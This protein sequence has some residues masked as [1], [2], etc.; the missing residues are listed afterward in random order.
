MK[1]FAPQNTITADSTST[2]IK[3]SLNSELKVK[4]STTIT[5]IPETPVRFQVQK[6][7]T[8]RKKIKHY[9]PSAEDSIKYNLKVR[10]VNNKSP[11]FDN[12][13]NDY[14]NPIPRSDKQWINTATTDNSGVIEIIKHE[15]ENEEI[16][17]TLNSL[18]LE[19]DSI[20]NQEN[21]TRTETQT[22]VGENSKLKEGQFIS[23]T[24]KDVISG[25]LIFVIAIVGFLRISN[26]KYLKELFSSLIYSQAA[27]KLTTTFSTQ[28]Q[29]PSFVLNVLFVLN[30]S[31][32][33]YL[34]SSYF[35][36]SHVKLL[37]L[38]LIPICML[39]IL[40]YFTFKAG[41]YRLVAYIFDTTDQTKEYLWIGQRHSKIGSLILLPFIA[42]IPYIE[43]S[44]VEILLKIGILLM[45]S[46][47][48][49]QIT[50]GLQLI[51]G[52]IASLFYL[53]LYLCALEILP[54]LI[55]YNIFKGA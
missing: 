33:L 2:E 5:S 31:I 40:A 8:P 18:A 42:I 15:K 50:R 11:L 36:L 54:L 4:S 41:M 26:F 52:N 51:L 28:N 48:L 34:F 35:Q 29:L 21:N 25:L 6:R 24:D 13:V 55:M 43:I 20:I 16:N 7:Y 32:F 3:P 27:R 45:I 39:I 38:W 49:I 17:Q 10:P 22:L 12:V 1:Y 53:F 14:L 47:Y 37:G 9:T 46:L 30:A 23:S 44:M 19:A